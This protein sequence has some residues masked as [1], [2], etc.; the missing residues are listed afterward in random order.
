[1]S[2]PVELIT[3][4]NV[5]KK[6]NGKVVLDNFSAVVRTG[7]VTGLIGKIG[8]GKSVLLHMLR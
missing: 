2:Q 3:I 5:T 6:F 8:A 4:E 7:Q 1:M